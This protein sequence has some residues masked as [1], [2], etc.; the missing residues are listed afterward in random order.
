MLIPMRGH[1][2][3]ILSKGMHNLEI[4]LQHLNTQLHDEN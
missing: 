3:V 4:L 1:T 2:F